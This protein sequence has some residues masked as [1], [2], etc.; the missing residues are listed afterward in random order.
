MVVANPRSGRT[1]MLAV[2]VAF[3]LAAVDHAGEEAVGL[4]FGELAFGQDAEDEAVFS[5]DLHA[6]DQAEE[7]PMGG[8]PPVKE[9]CGDVR[10]AAGGDEAAE[11]AKLTCDGGDAIA[12][13]DAVGMIGKA[14]HGPE[15]ACVS[16][17]CNPELEAQAATAAMLA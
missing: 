10:Q 11:N 17:L 3:G 13:G 9:S 4:G 6:S 15:A 2:L 8:M 5:G 7:Q 16:G 12:L 1:A 14:D